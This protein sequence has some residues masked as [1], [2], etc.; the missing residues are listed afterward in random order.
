MV[1]I[2]ELAAGVFLGI[3]LLYLVFVRLPI[4]RYNRMIDRSWSTPKETAAQ[5]EAAR[6][7]LAGRAEKE[8]REV[9]RAWD[10]HLA[11]AAWGSEPKRIEHVM[12]YLAPLAYVLVLSLIIIAGLF[13]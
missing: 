6:T 4:W 5:V 8:K 10:E 11:A 1:F 9:E 2:L 12:V 13:N 7:R 3:W